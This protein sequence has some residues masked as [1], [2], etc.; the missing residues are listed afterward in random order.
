MHLN[1][2]LADLPLNNTLSTIAQCTPLH[3]ETVFVPSSPQFKLLVCFVS[4]LKITIKKYEDAVQQHAPSIPTNLDRITL[5]YK[6]IFTLFTLY[7]A[8][9]K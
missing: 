6:Q 2:E 9:R 8:F 4:I 1:V 3:T 5:Q 7:L